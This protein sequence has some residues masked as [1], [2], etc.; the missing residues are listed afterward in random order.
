MIFIG[1]EHGSKGYRYIDPATR[2]LCISRDVN[3][4]ESK[5]LIFSVDNL[6]TSISYEDFNFDVFQPA[7]EVVEEPTEIPQNDS[8]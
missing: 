3:F 5:S 2:K 6:G 1:Y 8:I 7:E 4:E